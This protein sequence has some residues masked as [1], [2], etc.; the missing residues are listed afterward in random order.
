[1]NFTTDLPKKRPY[2]TYIVASA[3]KCERFFPNSKDEGPSY[4][5]H[6]VILNKERVHTQKYKSKNQS[7]HAN[8]DTEDSTHSLSSTCSSTESV[9]AE[10]H[11]GT[12]ELM[13]LKHIQK[14]YILCHIRKIDSNYKASRSNGK[15]DMSAREEEEAEDQN[16]EEEEEEDLAEDPLVKKLFCEKESLQ[17]IKEKAVQ[18]TEKEI[19][20]NKLAPLKVV[21][22]ELVRSR[23]EA[24]SPQE[25]L[26]TKQSL[27]SPVLTKG[28]FSSIGSKNSAFNSF[29]SPIL[30]PRL[31]PLQP[32][33][34]KEIVIKV[35]TEDKKP[36]S[37]VTVTNST[38]K[39]SLFEAFS[40]ADTTNVDYLGL[41][42]SLLFPRK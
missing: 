29:Q 1:M 42:S 6:A 13:D 28:C 37:P 17:S 36:I 25:P 12:D 19:A 30:I 21:S 22:T 24:T 4:R 27:A 23:S 16:E 11:D 18:N 40:L 10:K 33:K 31:S 39:K 38:F 32:E 8:L 3:V 35:K 15:R 41:F 34:S 26:V 14:N 5:M 20:I 7:H 2:V 9:D